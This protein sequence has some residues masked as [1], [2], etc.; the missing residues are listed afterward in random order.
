MAISDEKIQRL[1]G[2][3]RASNVKDLGNKLTYYIQCASTFF[4]LI[5]YGGSEGKNYPDVRTW[6]DAAGNS[7]QRSKFLNE[8]LATTETESLDEAIG[9][10]KQLE[11]YYKEN[12]RNLEQ[13]ISATTLPKEQLEEMSTKAE[14]ARAREEAIKR[15]VTKQSKLQTQRMQEAAQKRAAAQRV[16]TTKE[17]IAKEQ[18]SVQEQIEK[19]KATERNLE[20]RN[21]YVKVEEISQG[22]LSEEE[23][24]AIKDLRDQAK[25]NP[26]KTAEVVTQEIENR[27]KASAPSDI[28][29]EEVKLVSKQTAYEV[30]QN[31]Q[32]DSVPIVEA[33]IVS[34]LVQNPEAIGTIVPD[35]ALANDVNIIAQKVNGQNLSASELSRTVAKSLFGENFQKAILPNFKVTISTVPGPGFN[36]VYSLR[37]LPVQYS[38]SLEQQSKFLQHLG[39]FGTDEVKSR[40]ISSA[41][42][43]LNSQI[44]QL[45]TN[46]FLAK[47]FNNQVVQASLSLFGLGTPVNWVATNTLGRI[48]VSTG[49]GPAFGWLGEITGSTFFGIA[50][51]AV[52]VA[53]EAAGTAALGAGAAAAAETATEVAAATAAGTAAAAAGATAAGGLAGTLAGVM[54]TLG[55]WGGPLVAALGA[56]VGWLAG[57]LIGWII[58][59]LKKHKDSIKLLGLGLIGLG[60]FLG[61][62]PLSI[63]GVIMFLGALGLGGLVGLSGSLATV[64]LSSI[65]FLGSVAIG[66]T[67][68]VVISLLTFPVVVVLILFIINSG[69]YITPPKLSQFASSV[70]E[71][72]YIDIQKT[73]NPPGPFQNN[74]LPLTIEYTITISAK[75][76][77]LTNIKISDECNTTKKGSSPTCPTASPGIPKPPSEIS[78]TQPFSFSYKRTF[79]KPTFED[80][81]VV[82][83]VSVTAD[84]PEKKGN[85]A[86]NSASIKIGNPPD[87]CPNGWPIDGHYMITQTPGG[88]YSHSAIQ[89]MDIASPMGTNV[90]ATHS[91]IANWVPDPGGPYTPGYVEITSNCGGKTF[92]SL[93]AH[94]SS[95]SI[96]NGQQVTMG[97]SI[98]ASGTNGTGGGAGP[99]LHYEF[100]GLPMSPPYIPKAIPNGCSDNTG[101]CGYIP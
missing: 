96:H 3:L 6:K 2:N 27:I 30:V 32:Q 41:G 59:F 74:Q 64:G 34:T 37:K 9:A 40:L 81:L 90:K 36:N 15:E 89:A 84:V 62:W 10:I 85:T 28:S 55:S 99:H 101:K 4:P 24:K 88:G 7:I 93:Y 67:V 82:D 26:Q 45:P 63:L 66:I 100:R 11:R 47:A 35:T 44:A 13:N 20:N 68:P 18:K 57:K 70:I 65:R 48:A 50:P 87:Q 8:I 29:E 95:Y 71:S 21:V 72:P 5:Y 17:E 31:L 76:G 78:P 98:G 83:T 42:S 38:K 75:K 86:A 60:G 19:N 39:Q 97:Q 80:T 69:A 52:P 92:N 79:D 51:A 91:G 61:F 94:L 58:N 49:F 53:A 22:Q 33:T 1:I 16:K 12:F 56:A 23:A 43:W 73:P 77:S 46:S 25:A 14:E 54:A